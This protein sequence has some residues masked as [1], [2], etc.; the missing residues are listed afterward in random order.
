MVLH[1]N[2]GVLWAC[3]LWKCDVCVCVDTPKGP[4]Q[5][6]EL[7]PSHPHLG[8][9]PAL[10]GTPGSPR[11]QQVA[12]ALDSIATPTTE[13]GSRDENKPLGRTRCARWK[14]TNRKSPRLPRLWDFWQER[15]MT[16][17]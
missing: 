17:G 11:R 4:G 9:P 3:V 5:G 12:G 10:Q 13:P 15:G 6:Q 16:G 2:M 8:Q 14:G 1:P 7:C